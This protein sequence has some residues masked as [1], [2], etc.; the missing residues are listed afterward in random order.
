VVI[1]ASALVAILLGEPEGRRMIDAVAAAGTRLIGAPSLVEA[2]IVILA[3]RGPQGELAL[4]A[5]LS[6][7]DI[8]VVA[9]SP[10]AAAAARLAYTRYGKGFASP[11]ILNFGDCLTYG[12]AMDLG[13][14]LL[15]KGNDFSRTDVT[16]AQY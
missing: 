13:E 16:T 7:L 8:T 3:R 14:P 2:T 15:F 5:L 12:V 4:A 6:S 11:G 1:D 10:G 9:M